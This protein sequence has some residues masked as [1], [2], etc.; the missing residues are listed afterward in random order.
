MKARSNDI[1]AN[2]YSGIKRT[3]HDIW[4]HGLKQASDLVR[5]EYGTPIYDRDWGVLL[6]LDACRPDAIRAVAQEYDFISSVDTELSVGSN[7]PEWM[8]KNFTDEYAPEMTETIHITG[9]PFS[10]DKLDPNDFSAL[11]EVWRYEWDDSRLQTVRAES[12]TDRIIDTARNQSPEYLIGHYMQPHA[13]FVPHPDLTEYTDDYE[14]SIWRA[15]M[16]GRVETEQ[17][18][19][20][21]LD[22]LR[23]V[24]DE[25]ETV[26]NNIDEEKVVLSADHGECMGEWGLYGHGGPAISTLREVPWVETK[27]SD[28]GE[29]TPE[30]TN[31]EV[32]LSVDDRLES[33]GYIEQS[34]G[35]KSDGSGVS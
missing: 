23:Y 29:Y 15:T 25:V 5:A 2:G 8:A 22:N 24:L 27:A 32:D 26:L 31:D 11:D 13:S 10:A 9:N 19:E 14:R 17:V 1:W 33:L 6:I 20:A 30:I 4:K 3:A 34:R 7:S 28:S 16:R 18:W 12:I 35:E 21:Y